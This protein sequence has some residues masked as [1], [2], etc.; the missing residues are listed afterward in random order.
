M[1]R[2]WFISLWVF[3]VWML[4]FALGWVIVFLGHDL[5]MVFAVKTMQWGEYVAPL[6]HILYYILTGLFMMGFFILSLEYL[7]QTARKGMLLSG[8]LASIGMSLIIIALFQAG[9]TLYG[10]FPADLI[11]IL[12]M[13]VEGLAGTG[14]LL[15]ARLRKPGSPGVASPNQ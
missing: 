2:R 11:G 13:A 4:V 14:M 12:L 15:F 5:V 8:S 1:I 3:P 10:Y 7:K 9:L 6:I